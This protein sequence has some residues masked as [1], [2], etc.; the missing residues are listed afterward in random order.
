MASKQ[1]TLFSKNQ[2]LSSSG[3]AT[4]GFLAVSGAQFGPSFAPIAKE[5]LFR[6]LWTVL[7]RLY[8][9]AEKMVVSRLGL[10]ESCSRSPFTDRKSRVVGR[11]SQTRGSSQNVEALE[12][13]VLV[14]LRPGGH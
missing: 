3:V 13:N 14:V 7:E 9:F 8:R 1:L 5:M 6:I 12:G 2:A 4:I 10:M 11:L